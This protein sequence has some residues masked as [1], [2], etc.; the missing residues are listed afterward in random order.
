MARQTLCIVA[1]CCRGNDNQLT[2][3]ETFRKGLYS[4]MDKRGMG[5][6]NGLIQF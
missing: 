2:E 6:G 4:E 5:P 3:K 1:R